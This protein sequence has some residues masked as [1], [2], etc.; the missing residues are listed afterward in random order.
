[1]QYNDDLAFGM[2]DDFI[3]ASSAAARRLKV[4]TAS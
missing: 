1:V 2:I 4:L 3:R